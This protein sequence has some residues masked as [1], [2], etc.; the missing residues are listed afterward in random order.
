M[1][2]IKKIL[3]LVWMALGPV[4]MIFLFMQAI[5][6]VGLTHTEIEKTNTI[7]QWGIILFIF[8]PISLGLMIFGYYAWKGEYD[9]L[10][11]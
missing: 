7:L 9:R 5:D 4:A 2:G 11:D 10:T 1:N 8:F 6:K 3:G